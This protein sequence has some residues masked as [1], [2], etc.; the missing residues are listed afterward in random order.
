MAQEK[1]CPACGAQ[2]S[3]KFQFAKQ[4]VCEYCSSLLFLNDDT[5]SK[6]GMSAGLAELPSLLNLYEYF[7]YDKKKY[8]PVGCVQYEYDLGFWNEW[9]C[10]TS[11]QQGVWITVDEGS[12]TIEER[13]D[14]NEG[15]GSFDNY[16]V[17]QLCDLGKHGMMQVVEKKE[18]TLVAARGELPFKIKIGEQLKYIDLINQK[19]ETFSMQFFSGNS[20]EL[21]QG[22]W[23]DPFKIEIKGANK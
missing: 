14:L 9:W 5:V 1:N 19:G 15:V 6:A 21:F 12:I 8:L 17:G 13:I 2:L 16:R 18:C 4:I 23:I 10:L 22:Q 20:F 7:K 3:W 11:S